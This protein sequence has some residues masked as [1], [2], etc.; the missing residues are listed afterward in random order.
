VVRK[1][2]SA[3]YQAFRHKK[4]VFESNS[5]K[6]VN[7]KWREPAVVLRR[8]GTPNEKK[9]SLSFLFDGHG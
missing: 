1:P 3:S 7:A 2:L 6:R 9:E 8:E 4:G 5:N